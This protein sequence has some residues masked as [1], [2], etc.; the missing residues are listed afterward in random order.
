[1]AQSFNIPL[2][3][4]LHTLLILSTSTTAKHL[5]ITNTLPKGEVVTVHCK[6]GSEDLR[7]KQLWPGQQFSFEFSS[8]YTTLYFCR[9]WWRHRT[10]IGDVYK[11]PLFGSRTGF[12]HIYGITPNDLCV[13]DITQ[14]G[15]QE[16]AKQKKD[17]L[18]PWE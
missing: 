9:V 2:L 14:K 17:I 16:N 1:M 15:L 7:P 12:C 4:F 11:Q 18:Y 10:V 6:S 3:I 8:W 5:V 13:W